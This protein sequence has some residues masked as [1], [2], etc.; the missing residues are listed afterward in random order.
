MITPDL[1]FP[2]YVDEWTAGQ[3]GDLATTVTSGSRDW[4]QY[5]ADEGS[6]FIR[7]TN[8]PRGGIQLLLDDLR[9]V[10]LQED[11]SEGKRTSLSEDDILISITAELGKIGI[12]PSNFGTAYINQHT[13]LVRLNLEKADA[14]FIAHKL[15][16]KKM[17]NKINRLNDSGAKSGLNLPTIRS[18]PMSLPTLPEQRKIADFLTAVDGRIGQLIQKK[19]LLEDYKKGVMQQLFT[20]ALRFKDEQG[21]DFPDWEEKKLGAV[22][23]I[24]KGKGISKAEIADDGVTPCIR[25]GQLYTEY[26]E[27]ITEAKSKT[28]VPTEELV[29]SLGNEVIIPASGE[30]HIDIATAS[31]VVNS[32]IALGGDLN[33]IRTMLNGVFLAYYLNNACKHAI[34][35]VAQGSSVIHLYQDQLKGLSLSFPSLP[36]QTKIADFLS[37][38]DRKIET[39]ATQITETQTFKRGLLQ[40]MFV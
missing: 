6:K 18:F 29:L 20:Q 31:C 15:S 4:A 9:F 25:Y 14:R 28:N 7:M 24:I 2:R 5:Y 13:A 32:G 11:S 23:E 26:S 30:T 27:V 34:A 1:R 40:Q 39:V 33:V 21:N 36:E 35:S 17:N 16:S 12:I 8:L 10:K 22:C 38:L 19:A 3:L 37:A